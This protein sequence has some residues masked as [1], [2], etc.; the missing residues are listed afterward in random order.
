MDR[1]NFMFKIFL[2]LK[3]ILLP[4]NRNRFRYT[5]KKLVV[6]SGE[7]EGKRSKIRVGD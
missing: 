2:V 4:H 3:I 7:K 1:D 5:E 6:T